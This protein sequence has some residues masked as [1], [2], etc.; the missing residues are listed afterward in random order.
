[1]SLQNI[2]ETA[3]DNRANFGAT[4]CPSDVRSAVEEVLAGLDNGSLRV[5]EKIDGEWVVL[6]GSKK[7]YYCHSKS[8]TTN[9]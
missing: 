3:F 9:P 6:N 2:I 1:M 4:D 5:A 8:M 7:P